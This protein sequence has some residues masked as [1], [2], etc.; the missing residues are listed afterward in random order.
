[1]N[2]FRWENK[3]THREGMEGSLERGEEGNGSPAV[4]FNAVSL[5]F[6]LCLSS[7]MSEY[8]QNGLLK[9]TNEENTANHLRGCCFSSSVFEPST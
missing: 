6:A 2:V 8:T 4:S 5:P 3:Q 7:R 9:D 1:M